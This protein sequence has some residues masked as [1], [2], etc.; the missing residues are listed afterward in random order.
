MIITFEELHIICSY[1]LGSVF[2]NGLYYS[3]V[4]FVCAV[5]WILGWSEVIFLHEVRYVYKN[6]YI[7]AHVYVA[8]L[9]Q[10]SAHTGRK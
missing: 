8:L 10:S 1:C 9:L 6:I 3:L 5:S 2:G 4:L 7:Y